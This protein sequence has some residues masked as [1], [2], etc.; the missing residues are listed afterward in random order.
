MFFSPAAPSDPTPRPE[1][2]LGIFSFCFLCGG[3]AGAMC[4]VFVCL[5]E[6]MK[7]IGRKR[8]G[9][10][11]AGREQKNTRETHRGGEVS[12]G[13]SQATNNDKIYINI[14]LDEWLI[15]VCIV[16]RGNVGQ[17]VK[18]CRMP[19]YLKAFEK[20]VRTFGLCV[21]LNGVQIEDTA[22]VHETSN[23]CEESDVLLLLQM[24]QHTLF[25]K[26]RH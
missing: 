22:R 18:M 13:T 24:V 14:I 1:P 2:T 15:L 17:G 6:G 4:M 10:V 23:R 11:G 25:T 19:F 5:V 3:M 16:Y 9:V 12:R 20:C 7:R 21:A 8:N 26:R